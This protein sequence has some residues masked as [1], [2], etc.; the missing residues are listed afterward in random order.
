MHSLKVLHLFEQW[1]LPSWTCWLPEDTK[2]GNVWIRTCRFSE[3]VLTGHPEGFGCREGGKHGQFPTCFRTLAG[4][5]ANFYKRC[6]S[7]QKTEQQLVFKIFF[8]FFFT[9]CL[10]H[11]V[12]CW[13][14]QIMS[15]STIAVDAVFAGDTWHQPSWMDDSFACGVKVQKNQHQYKK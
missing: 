8:F 4:S 10:C 12:F 5:S 15:L 11:T 1:V 7:F 13:G 6:T 2:L 3:K 14:T 9:I